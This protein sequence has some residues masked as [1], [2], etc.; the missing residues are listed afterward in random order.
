MAG[1]AGA[2]LEHVPQGAFA[3]AR[4]DIDRAH[5]IGQQRVV[6][7]Y[8]LALRGTVEERILALQAK[9]R[10]LIEATLDEHSPLMAGLAENELEELLG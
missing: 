1:D 3:V 8:R 4:P 5:R 7:A 6:T 2:R 10:G 9:K